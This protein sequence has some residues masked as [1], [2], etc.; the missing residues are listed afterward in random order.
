MEKKEIRKWIKRFYC[1]PKTFCKDCKHYVDKK[2][3]VEISEE[4]VE[5]ICDIVNTF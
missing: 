4:L 5:H 1:S 2:C 3:N